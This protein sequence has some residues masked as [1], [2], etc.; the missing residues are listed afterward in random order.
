MSLIYIL[1][2]R[3]NMKKLP[4]DIQQSWYNIIRRFQ[5]VAKS[6]GVSII[7]LT[8]LVDD[9]GNPI[10]WSNPNIIKIEPKA[11]KEKVID[12]LKMFASGGGE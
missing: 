1:E 2:E 9:N 11:N 3:C 5:S 7:Q 10:L 8:I 4:E 6:D 12:I